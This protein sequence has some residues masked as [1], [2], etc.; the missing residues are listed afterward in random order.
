MTT[1]DVIKIFSSTWESLPTFDEWINHIGGVSGY[2]DSLH[3]DIEEQFDYLRDDLEN[4]GNP[5]QLIEAVE[6]TLREEYENWLDK[7]SSLQFPLTVFRCVTLNLDPDQIEEIPNVGVYWTD[8][9]SHAQCHWGNFDKGLAP[10]VLAAE[11][12][13]DDIDWEKT[14]RQNMDIHVGRDEQELR[15]KPGRRIHLIG[16]RAGG[17]WEKVSYWVQ[18]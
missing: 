17:T 7:Y 18:T 13:S 16:I 15:L 5:Q 9:E 3:I 2:A 10:H 1:R 12:N 14:I 8:S 6:E 4:P 11:I